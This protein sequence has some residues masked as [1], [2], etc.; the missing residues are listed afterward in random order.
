MVLAGG[1]CG[2]IRKKG[3]VNMRIKKFKVTKYNQISMVYEQG[4][5]NQDEYSFTCSE[6]ARP[7]FYV[8][9]AVLAEHVIDMCELPEDYMERI[10]VRGVS[11][12]YGGEK[13]VMGATISA[14]M[15]LYESNQALNINTP[16]KA[17]DSYSDAPAQDSQLLGNDC[18]KALMVLQAECKAYIQGDRAQG[19]LFSEVRPEIADQAQL[20]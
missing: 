19:S 20:N 14:G 12:S 8:A 5:M 16:H 4:S 15:K 17:T 13:E 18:I 6:K 1:K 11:Y 7:E 9:M 10:K 2:G 3:E